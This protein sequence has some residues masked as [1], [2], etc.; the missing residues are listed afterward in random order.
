[1]NF[2]PRTELRDNAIWSYMLAGRYGRAQ[3][4]YAERVERE[5][6]S[7]PKRPRTHA[8]TTKVANLISVLFS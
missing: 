3:Q 4:Q 1:M 5:A 2:V 6:A 8:S 7:R